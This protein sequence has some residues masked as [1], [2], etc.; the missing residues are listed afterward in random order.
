MSNKKHLI[1]KVFLELSHGIPLS[2][3]VL[4]INLIYVLNYELECPKSH[5]LISL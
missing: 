3:F 4:Y 2:F 5:I 1:S